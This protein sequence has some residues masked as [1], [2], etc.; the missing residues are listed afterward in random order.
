MVKLGTISSGAF[1]S[2]I[3]PSRILIRLIAV[4]NRPSALVMGKIGA[5]SFAPGTRNTPLVM[6]TTEASAT[7]G[8]CS[9][10]RSSCLATRGS[11]AWTSATTSSALL[12]EMSRSYA[13]SVRRAPAAAA[14]TTPP[15]TPTMTASARTDA[16]R[17][18]SSPLARIQMAVTSLAPQDRGRFQPGCDASG[19]DR[20]EVR[21][22]DRR[23]DGEE[24]G[25]HRHDGFRDHAEVV[26]EDV[27]SP[28]SADHSERKS[29]QYGD[30]GERC[31]L[32][33]D[34]DGNLPPDEPQRLQ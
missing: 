8:R 10:S 26:G 15:I 33:G 13:V 24:H 4:P 27:P 34:G 18:R 22:E 20:Q 9:T 3:R 6:V 2:Y 31:R 7:C 21:N 25:H 11:L 28:A 19:D 5:S 32:P 12:A 30:R 14:M 16:S 17:D 29:D 1:G 23:R